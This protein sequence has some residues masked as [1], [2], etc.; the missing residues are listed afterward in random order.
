MQN[1]R[2]IIGI[3]T[4]FCFGLL[5]QGLLA[6]K[7]NNLAMVY[8]VDAKDGHEADFLEAITEHAQ[9]RRDAGDPWTWHVYQVA[10]G[11]ELGRYIIRSGDHAWADFDAYEQLNVKASA[12]WN[13]TVGPHIAEVTNAI[14]TMDEDV[15]NW[16]P[17]D[18]INFVS[19]TSYNLKPGKWGEFTEVITKYHE[20]IMEHGYDTNYAFVWAMEGGNAD[21]HL[22][23]PY[24]SY[25]DMEGPEEK[26]REFMTRIMGKEEAKELGMKFNKC[27]ESS[28]SALLRYIPEL[29]VLHDE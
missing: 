8:Y 12:H 10:V 6:E 20:T 25:A 15:I 23:L 24:S 26:L 2:I 28:T 29:S 1:K 9:W 21:V 18:E 11:E 27:I 16:M 4:V 5:S 22:V 13:E 17:Q 3:L 7:A 19:V 14:S